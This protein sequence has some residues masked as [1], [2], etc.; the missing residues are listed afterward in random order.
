MQV[1][2]QLVLLQKTLLN[3]EGLGRMLYDDLDLWV[4]AKPFLENWM[5]DQVGARALASQLKQELPQ[6]G[7]KLP[8]LPLLAHKVLK[9]A[10]EGNLSL[11]L[12]EKDL[13]QIKQEIRGATTQRNKTL[14]GSSILITSA[15]VFATGTFAIGWPIGGAIIGGILLTQG[16]SE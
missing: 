15:I 12:H 5:K 11:K 8:Q 3:I 1:Q 14:A 13:E 4:T 7:E 2:P 16:M 10:S 9:Q 6:W